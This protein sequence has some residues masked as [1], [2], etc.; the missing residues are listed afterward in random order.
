[1]GLRH[2]WIAVIAMAGCVEVF[3]LERPE[4]MADEEATPMPEGDTTTS[5]GGEPCTGVTAGSL[6]YELSPDATTWER[7]RDACDGRGATLA[8]IESQA[9]RTA[10]AKLLVPGKPA[11]IGATDKGMLLYRWLDGSTVAGDGW[12][13][14][15]P[16][17]GALENC[18]ALFTQAGIDGWRDE[19]C[20]ET[21]LYVCERVMK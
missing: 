7:A 3:G 10:V 17:G 5:G 20:N 1:M 16:D 11:Y 13:A 18:L 15:E 21:F 12:L 9:D 2:A 8:K 6:C 19:P 14:M 4:S